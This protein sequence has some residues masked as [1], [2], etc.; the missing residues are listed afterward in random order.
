MCLSRRRERSERVESNLLGTVGTVI[1]RRISWLAIAVA[2][3]TLAGCNAPD[4]ASTTSSAPSTSIDTTIDQVNLGDS[5]SAGTGVSPLAAGSPFLCQRSSRNFAQILTERQHYRLTDVSCAGADT[6]DLANAQYDGVPAQFDAVTPDTDL[7]TM[8]IGGNDN[9][10]YSGSIRAC[11]D[12]ASSDP[13]GSPCRDRYGDSLEKPILTTTYPSLLTALRQV[14]Q[15]APHARVVIVGY[16]WILPATGGC[17][18]TMRVAAGD[19]PYLRHLQATLNDAIRRAAAQTGATYVDMEAVSEG[20]DAC[21]GSQ[22]W[23]EPMTRSGPG[24][25]HPNARGQQAIADQVARSL[26]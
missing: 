17:Y 13:S 6:A 10:T 4:D 22:R 1:S 2:A 20:H 26:A 9:D 3:C 11:R 25:V 21:A 15:K 14:Q 12:V 7:V 23:I 5:Y 8:M 24:A 16:P 19:V 18:P